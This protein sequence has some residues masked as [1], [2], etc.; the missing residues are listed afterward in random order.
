MTAV[1]KKDNTNKIK[2]GR[3]CVSDRNLSVTQQ[4]L[5]LNTDVMLDTLR[6][7]LVNGLKSISVTLC[8]FFVSLFNRTVD[9]NNS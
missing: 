1:N 7:L 8:T 3:K 4:D 2:V 5:L 9:I 6:V